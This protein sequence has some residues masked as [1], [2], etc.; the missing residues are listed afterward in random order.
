MVTAGSVGS[1]STRLA[2]S[3]HLTDEDAEAQKRP[4]GKEPRLKSSNRSGL[5]QLQS[6]HS[7]LYEML[8]SAEIITQHPEEAG[9]VKGSR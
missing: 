5:V 1:S 6:E 8:S 2:S 3:A 4:P 9:T 7:F